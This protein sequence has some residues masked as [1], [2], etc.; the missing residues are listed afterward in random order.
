V[1]KFRRLL[2]TYEENKD[3]VAVGAYRP[4]TQP[5]LDEALQRRGLFREFLSQG[6]DESVTLDQGFAQLQQVLA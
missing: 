3:L 1:T 4:G 5:E 2:A 6:A